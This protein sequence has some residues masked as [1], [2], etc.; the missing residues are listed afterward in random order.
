MDSTHTS[1]PLPEVSANALWSQG[2]DC[3]CVGRQ[4]CVPHC[5][6]WLTQEE[7]VLEGFPRAQPGLMEALK[8]FFIQFL[9][10]SWCWWLS[11]CQAQEEVNCVK[12]ISEWHACDCFPL[13]NRGCKGWVSRQQKSPGMQRKG[14]VCIFSKKNYFW[15]VKR[16]VLCS[17]YFSPRVASWR[18]ARASAHVVASD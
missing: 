10:L 7:A 11:L 8:N 13:W 14:G 9:K 1:S 3:G 4:I 15:Y 16:R 5:S 6:F 17:G 12:H 2:E 18:K